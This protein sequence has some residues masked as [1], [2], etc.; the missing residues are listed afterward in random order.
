MTEGW[1]E[2]AYRP[3]PK[4]A[5]LEALNL[6]KEK[7]AELKKYTDTYP[8][9]MLGREIYKL[10]FQDASAKQTLKDLVA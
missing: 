10:H 5:S 1:Q 7:E 2:A 9:I 4:I 3:A 8:E 6:S